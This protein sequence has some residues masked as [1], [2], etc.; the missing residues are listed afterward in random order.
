[1]V[2]FAPLSLPVATRLRHCSISPRGLALAFG[3][4]AAAAVGIGAAF[5]AVGA[6][7]VLPFAGLEAAALA[8]A[9]VA[10]ARRAPGGD[11]CAPAGEGN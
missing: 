5:A 4:L 2:D 1:M 11:L 3:L 9:F 7:L 6:W 8:A 10:V